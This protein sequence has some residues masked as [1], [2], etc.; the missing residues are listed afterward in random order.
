MLIG[1]TTNYMMADGFGGNDSHKLK[2]KERKQ[3][4]KTSEKTLLSI[5]VVFLFPC[6]IY[7]CLFFYFQRRLPELRKMKN[8]KGV[9]RLS[10]SISGVYLFVTFHDCAAKTGEFHVVF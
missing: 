4:K 8:N 2:P 9:L 5:T 10:L 6:V 3:S 1:I 7:I